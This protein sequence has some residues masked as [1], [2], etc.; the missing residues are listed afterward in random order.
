MSSG[1]NPNADY[2]PAG[3]AGYTYPSEY[4]VERFYP[5]Y[6]TSTRPQPTGLPE[7][8]GYGG[9]SF[10]V[11]LSAIDV[12]QLSNLD[13]TKVVLIR[14]GFSTHAMNMGQRYVQLNSTYTADSTGAAT[15]HVSQVPPNPAILVPGPALIFVVVNGV[16][17]EGQWVTIGN[18]Q[19]G[20]QPVS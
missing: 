18:G 11:K 19:L 14:P 20:P 8:L 6:Y 7:T 9:A 13:N 10:D 5:D 2:V 1:S 4:R 12:G 17:S 15:L 16:P 3:A